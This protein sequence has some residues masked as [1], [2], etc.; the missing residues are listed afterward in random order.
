MTVGTAIGVIGND[1]PPEELSSSVPTDIDV[2]STVASVVGVVDTSGG[3]ASLSVLGRTDVT[4]LEEELLIVETDSCIV[5]DACSSELELGLSAE[6]VLFWE[7]EADDG[8]CNGGAMLLL[9]A[10]MM[11]AA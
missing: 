6:A 2:A 1:P 9:A 10:L 5:L 7:L 8:S 4:R 3:F 11:S